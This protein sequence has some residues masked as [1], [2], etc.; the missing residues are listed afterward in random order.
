MKKTITYIISDISKMIALEWICTFRDQNQTDLSFVLLNENDSEIEAFVKHHNYPFI[1]I[2]YRG[3]KDLPLAIVST[4][5]FLRKIRPDI[6]HCH[7]FDACAVGLTAAWLSGVKRRIYTRHYSTLHHVYFSKAVK[8]DR[9]F[10]KIATEIIAI[11]ALVKRVLIERERVPEHKVHLINHGFLSEEFGK[12]DNERI[13]KFAKKYNIQQNDILIGVIA[14][15]TELKGVH[16][17]IPAFIKILSEYP[18]AKLLL[19]NS[20]GNDE[21]YIRSLLQQIPEHRIIEVKYERDM[22]ALYNN[23]KVYVHT[24]I[25]EHIEAFGQTYVEAL[26][27]GVPSVFTLSG[28]AAEFIVHER[29]ALVVDFQNEEQIYHAIKRLL[30]DHQLYDRISQQGKKDAIAMFDLPVMIEKLEKLYLS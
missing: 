29:N 30:D 7:L 11:S 8:Y 13:T 22:G 3:K 5:K 10:N 27:A 26:M 20:H 19:A 1:R 16:H 25:N 28:I 6:V 18:V 12:I 15:Y 17:I 24:P 4:I 9:F 21:K 14:R 23:L 2:R